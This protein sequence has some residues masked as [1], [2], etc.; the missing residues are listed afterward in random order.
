MRGVDALMVI[1]RFPLIILLAVLLRPRLLN[2]LGV[3]ILL[4][5]P[6]VARTIRAQ[7]LSIRERDAIRFVRFSGG[8][9][10]YVLRHHLWRELLPLFMAKAAG[11]ASHAIVA[12][13]GLSFLGLGDPALKS[14]GTMI[15]SAL[16]YPG[17]FWTPAWSWWLLPPSILVSLAVLAFTL[18]AA[19]R[20]LYP[21]W[22]VNLE[23]GRQ[24]RLVVV[25]ESGGGK[26]SLAWAMLGRP[27]P[28]Q[29]VLCGN[30][31]F[32]GK[33][34]L[35]L[36]PDQRARLYYRSV[37]LVPQNVQDTFHPTQRLWESAREVLRK[38]ATN[39]LPRRDV[40]EAV[41]SLGKRL[42]VTAKPWNSWPHQLSGGQKQRMG[43]IL[44]LLNKPTLLVL[45]EP[46]H[47]LDELTRAALV[48]FLQEWQAT[49]PCSVALFTHDIGLARSWGKRIVVLYRG[50]IV[51][52]MPAGMADAPR[53]P[54]TM[55]LMN[56]AVRL[57]DAPDSRQ[58][59]TGH[60]VPLQ[61]PPEGCGYSDRCPWTESRCDRERPVLAGTGDHRIR[62]RREATS[63]TTRA[64]SVP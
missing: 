39:R 15:R 50:E 60:A 40:I 6:G 46:T 57:G 26:T 51:E 10:V 43:L 16:D 9:F 12:E 2:V 14:W 32:E 35:S 8:G 25:G 63:R 42:D 56:S 48:A 45:D 44:A 1:P 5:W 27:L 37:A 64:A 30:V 7:V 18:F 22:D 21:L 4:S 52:E 20:A 29:S 61:A 13:A 33:D 34:L 47:A 54:Y 19:R 58:P 38:E 49:N 41:D 28:G 11:T 62:C 31:L 23:I 53:H 55:G 17:I 59:I 24:E 3:L 36:P